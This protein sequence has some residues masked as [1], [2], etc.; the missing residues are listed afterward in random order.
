MKLSYLTDTL[1]YKALWK[2][3]NDQSVQQ[4]YTSDLLSDVMGNAPEDSLLITIQGHK[5][6]VAVASLAG[7]KGILLCN[8]R[9]AP[10]EMLDAAAREGISVFST[11]D[12]QF[13]ASYKIA[14]GLGLV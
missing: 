13:S 12:D 4:A 10:D 9:A 2:A 6:T 3:D 8:N 11:T 14:K 1:S 5:N 7:M